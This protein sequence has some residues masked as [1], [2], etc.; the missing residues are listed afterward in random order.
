MSSLLSSFCAFFCCCLPCAA[1]TNQY[2]KAPSKSLYEQR[3]EDLYPIRTDRVETVFDRM[4]DDLKATASDLSQSEYSMAIR[5]IT[6]MEKVNQGLSSIVRLRTDDL[7]NQHINSLTRGGAEGGFSA[8]PEVLAERVSVFTS[9]YQKAKQQGDLQ[10]FFSCFI[11]GDPCLS[12]RSESLYKY[13][14][15][16]DGINIEAIP[17]PEKKLFLPGSVFSE[18]ILVHYDEEADNGTLTSQMLAGYVTR[19]LGTVAPEFA[20]FEKSEGGQAFLEYLDMIG[21]YQKGTPVNWQALISALARS[22]HFDA[23]FKHSMTYVV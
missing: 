20:R 8:S 10:G 5:T 6:D 18:L 12:G 4:R 19:N 1:S 22:R 16:L 14:A 7:R 21:I 2:Q 3:D 15:T 23:V 17:D 9:T 13:S 11:K